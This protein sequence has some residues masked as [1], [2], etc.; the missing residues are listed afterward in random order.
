M[1]LTLRSIQM[2]GVRLH[3]FKGWCRRA[4]RVVKGMGCWQTVENLLLYTAAP[5]RLLLPPA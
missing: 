1:H 4:R 5:R 2:M 3:G